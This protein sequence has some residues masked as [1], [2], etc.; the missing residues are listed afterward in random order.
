[1][2][3]HTDNYEKIHSVIMTLKPVFLLLLTGT[4]YYF[5]FVNFGIGIP[6]VIRKI[7]G[8]KC[9]GCGM[10]HAVVELLRFNF[11]SAWD[12]N[13]LSITVFP[14]VCLYL[15]FRWVREKENSDREF[16]AWEYIFLCVLLVTV[17]IYGISRNLF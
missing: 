4:V 7:T 14:A 3:K 10:T 11:K 8:Y 2:M 5:V 16:R 1:M 9:P 13:A 15:L 12:Y 6:C 17:L